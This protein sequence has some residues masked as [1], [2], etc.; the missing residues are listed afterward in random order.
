MRK[1]NMLG[2]REREGFKMKMKI[3]NLKMISLRINSIN[4]MMKSRII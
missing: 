3:M 4:S 1:R 2:G